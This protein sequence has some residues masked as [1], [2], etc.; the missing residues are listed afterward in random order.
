MELI[1]KIIA[2]FVLLAQQ[3]PAALLAI[4]VLLLVLSN[5]ITNAAKLPGAVKAAVKR[6]R[7]PEAEP[8]PDRCPSDEGD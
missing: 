3:D 6:R 7:H 2:D 4:A 1:E 5:L 8:S